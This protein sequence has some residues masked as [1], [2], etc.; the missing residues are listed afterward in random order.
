MMGTGWSPIRPIARP[1]QANCR[2]TSSKHADRHSAR[3]V[4]LKS[5]TQT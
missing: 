3:R 2:R 5:R 4:W 1:N